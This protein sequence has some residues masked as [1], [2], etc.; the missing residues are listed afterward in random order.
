[1]CVCVCFGEEGDACPVHSWLLCHVGLG[2][3]QHT[4]REGSFIAVSGP[5]VM[6]QIHIVFPMLRSLAKNILQTNNMENI[7]HLVQDF[8]FSQ[9]CQKITVLRNS[10]PI[11]LHNGGA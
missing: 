3:C 8:R 6:P 1:M 5:C 9:R 11:Y 10:T 4:D 7:S 2:L